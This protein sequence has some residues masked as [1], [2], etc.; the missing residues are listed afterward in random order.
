[1]DEIIL[2]KEQQSCFHWLHGKHQDGGGYV[3]SLGERVPFA[4]GT[5]DGLCETSSVFT[6]RWNV[7]QALDARCAVDLERR[8]GAHVGDESRRFGSTF[9]PLCE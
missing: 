5:I 2:H 4:C 9:K 1:M 3:G 8:S 7:H 6:N